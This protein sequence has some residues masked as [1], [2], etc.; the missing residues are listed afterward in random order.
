MKMMN[1]QDL[2]KIIT[3]EEDGIE[4]F[5]S[6]VDIPTKI[7]LDL[8]IKYLHQKQK[9]KIT[10]KEI[11]QKSKL[12]YNT[13]YKIDTCQ[14]IPQVNTLLKLFDAVDCAVEFKIID[15]RNF[16]NDCEW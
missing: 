4:V 2:T 1:D 16:Q 13:V 9:Y 3:K 12:S 10:R 14:E 8:L 15:K 5:K 11:C 7:Y 6:D